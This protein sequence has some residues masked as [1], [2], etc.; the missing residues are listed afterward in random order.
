MAQP[1][2][3]PDPNSQFEIREKEPAVFKS[4]WSFPCATSSSISFL[5]HAHTSSLLFSSFQFCL[6][7]VLKGLP[8][9]TKWRDWGNC[10]DVSNGHVF[11]CIRTCAQLWINACCE[12]LVLATFQSN[13]VWITRSESMQWKRSRPPHLECSIDQDAWATHRFIVMN[14]LY[15]TK[16][17]RKD[18]WLV[19]NKFRVTSNRMWVFG[20]TKEHSDHRIW[21]KILSIQYS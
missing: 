8:R 21:E 18:R 17:L 12:L 20:R 5:N 9:N 19:L 3:Q 15:I 4:P 10:Q 11:V 13:A 1:G 7:H 14:C 6:I 16:L 2:A